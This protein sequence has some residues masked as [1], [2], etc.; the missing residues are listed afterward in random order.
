MV[1]DTR[2]KRWADAVVAAPLNSA[3]E[4]HDHVASDRMK[5]TTD[6][7]HCSD[8]STLCI[9]SKAALTVYSLAR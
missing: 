4:G 9:M 1:A 5:A 7:T 8:R 2:R 6:D 3:E